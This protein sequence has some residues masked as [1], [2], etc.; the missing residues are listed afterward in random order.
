M[1][2]SASGGAVVQEN[3]MRK[4]GKQVVS[5]GALEYVPGKTSW[6]D[7]CEGDQRTCYPGRHQRQCGT[8][9]LP[10]DG[11]CTHVTPRHT[12]P[13]WPR[14]VPTCFSYQG[15][16]RANST[17]K[18]SEDL[19][20]LTDSDE[21]AYP[22]ITWPLVSSWSDGVSHATGLYEAKSQYEGPTVGR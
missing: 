19:L 2:F 6:S 10:K 5:S 8:Q 22:T 12:P 7:S 14:S 9:L 17:W 21:T 16:L 20:N 13:S 4:F 1:R 18:W 11:S 3:Y 15:S